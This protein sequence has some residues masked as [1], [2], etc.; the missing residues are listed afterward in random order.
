MSVGKKIA[1]KAEAAKGAVK[2]LI[3]RA[4][5]NTRLRAEGRADQFKGNAK[6]AGAK[7]KDAFKH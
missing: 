6:Q 7:V 3:G 2:K 4:T 5:G 1:H